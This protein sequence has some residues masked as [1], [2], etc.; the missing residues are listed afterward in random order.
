MLDDITDNACWSMVWHLWFTITTL[1]LGRA[2]GI[3]QLLT[4][5]STMHYLLHIWHS[6]KVVSV[7]KICY[8]W[9]GTLATNV[10]GGTSQDILGYLRH[11]GTEGTFVTWDLDHQCL[12]WEK[13]GHPG[14]SES[15]RSKVSWDI[16]RHPRI[17]QL[18]RQCKVPKSQVQDVLGYPD[19]SHDIPEYSVICTH[20]R[21]MSRG[22]ISWRW[23]DYV[24]AIQLL[25][26]CGCKKPF[27]T[28]C[29][30]TTSDSPVVLKLLNSG[31]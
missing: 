19:I 1:F 23:K 9:P 17:S 25:Y 7:G 5:N 16:L 12:R 24:K 31:S 11:P 21:H 10:L 13:L 27:C 28:E 15:P 14:I 4:I 22:F 26:M 20:D 6:I 2:F 18:W 30:C 8:L 29:V 3:R